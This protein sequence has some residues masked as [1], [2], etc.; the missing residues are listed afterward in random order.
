[1]PI[2]CGLSTG[3]TVPPPAW[4]SR[5]KLRLC[6]GPAKGCRVAIRHMGLCYSPLPHTGTYDILI[7]GV[8][9]ESCVPLPGDR[10]FTGI[11]HRSA[12]PAHR[13]C[14]LSYLSCS[15]TGKDLPE[16]PKPAVYT[17]LL[18]PRGH[19]RV[20]DVLSSPEEHSRS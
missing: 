18:C 7:R 17:Q 9:L 15:R 20:H 10:M 19:P 13:P 11:P 16:L 8:S 2:G 3:G 5:P 1:M 14:F 4:K 6:Y 12:A